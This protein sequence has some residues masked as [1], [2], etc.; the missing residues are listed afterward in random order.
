M[1]GICRRATAGLNARF[2]GAESLHLLFGGQLWG[3]EDGAVSPFEVAAIRVVP[4]SWLP[5]ACR[6]GAPGTPQI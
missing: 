4:Q 1:A 2:A 6:R 5:S 3:T